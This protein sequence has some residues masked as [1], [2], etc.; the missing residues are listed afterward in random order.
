MN[1]R[2]LT[3]LI[4]ALGILSLTGYSQPAQAKAPVSIKGKATYFWLVDRQIDSSVL[5]DSSYFHFDSVSA[6][7]TY[8]VSELLEGDQVVIELSAENVSDESA[9]TLKSSML[10][11]LA[12]NGVKQSPQEYMGASYLMYSKAAGDT[13]ISA[14]IVGQFK[15]FES[16]LGKQGKLGNVRI[17]PTIS[18]ARQ[19]EDQAHPGEFYLALDP[20]VKPDAQTPGV[21]EFSTT[22]TMSH[23][24]QSVTLP[25]DTTSAFGD[26]EWQ[27]SVSVPK[28]TKLTASKLTVSRKASSGATAKNVAVTWCNNTNSYCR[29]KPKTLTKG[30]FSFT[31]SATNGSMWQEAKG[32]LLTLKSTTKKIYV[33]Q[34]ISVN[35]ALTSGTVLTLGLMA[36]TK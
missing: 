7:L 12:I 17:V 28:N 14:T 29:T 32:Q 33:S 9:L 36:V 23:S 31:A 5:S 15:Q 25:T 11:L 1:K 2:N 10:T 6:S 19:I 8:D 13:S 16:S 35:S 34:G 4:C 18:V 21:S 3:K 27:S 24:G 20:L 26:V 30:Y 22:F